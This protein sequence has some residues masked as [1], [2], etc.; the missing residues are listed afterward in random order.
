MSETRLI[1]SNM[2]Q[3]LRSAGSSLGNVV[4]TTVWLASML[5]MENLNGAYKP[6]FPEAPPAR[7]V[8]GAMLN[9]GMK[10]QIDCIVQA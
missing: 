8:C 2:S 6:F 1:L 4:K 7:T 9:Y 3:I 5:E 10:V